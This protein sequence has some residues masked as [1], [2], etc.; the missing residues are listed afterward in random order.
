MADSTITPLASISSPP[1]QP[2]TP[3]NAPLPTLLKLSSH[4]E[5]NIFMRSEAQI[6][7]S[8]LNGAKQA[9]RNP[10]SPPEPSSFATKVTS[11]SHNWNAIL[12]TSSNR[13]TL[14]NSFSSN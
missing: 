5:T 12:L 1:S 6:S 13:S 14:S 10:A 4:Q 2:L 7:A 3:S 9:L 11:Y 8:R